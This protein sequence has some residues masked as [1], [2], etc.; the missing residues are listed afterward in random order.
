MVFPF[1]WFPFERSNLSPFGRGI[2]RR[3]AGVGVLREFADHSVGVGETDAA[4]IADGGVEGTEN[5]FAA[6]DLDGAAEKE[7]DDFHDGDLDGLLVFEE[8]EFAE[9][10]VGAF[11]AADHALVEVAVIFSAKR[12]RAATDSGDLNVL[13]NGN[14]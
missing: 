5:E 9:A 6:L 7:I 8:G 10:L 13:A 12:G 4:G 14:D 2:L 11:D 1:S 3:I